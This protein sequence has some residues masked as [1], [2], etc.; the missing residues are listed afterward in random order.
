MLRRAINWQNWSHL[1]TA[2]PDEDIML[3]VTDGRGGSYPLLNPCRLTN[4][5]WVSSKRRT[6]LEVQPVKWRKFQKTA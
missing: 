1:D 2:P 6:P 4:E 3:L 5:G